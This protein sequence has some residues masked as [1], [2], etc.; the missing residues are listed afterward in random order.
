[1]PEVSPRGTYLLIAD[2]LRKEIEQGEL[3]GSLPSEAA[4]MKA[5][6]VSR[7]TIR[8]ALKMLESER[9]ITSVQGL[10]GACP[11]PPSR[12]LLSAWWRSSRRTRSP[13]AIGTRQRRTSASASGCPG[14]PCVTLLRRWAGPDC[15]P[16]CMA[17]GGRCALFQPPRRSHSLAFHGA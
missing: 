8:R 2:A 16:L 1:M 3:K 7:N 9:L 6:D 11:G 14:Q 4:L 15:S 13:S 5:H 12:L 17:R 10:A